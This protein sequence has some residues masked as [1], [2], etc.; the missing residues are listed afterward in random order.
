MHVAR[1]L[2][3]L[4][5]PHDPERSSRRTHADGIWASRFAD[6][7]TYGLYWGVHVAALGVFFTGVTTTALV[8]F[9]ITFWGRLFG[10][11]GGYHRYFAHK[12][13]KT[14]RPFQFLLAL[15]GTAA[16]Q[17]GPLWWASLHRIHHRES[18]GPGDVHS[19]K[20]GFYYSHQGWIFDKRWQATRLDLIP[21]FAK[22][23]EIQWLNRWHFVPPVALAVACFAIGGLPGLFWGFFLSTTLLWHATYTINSLSHLFG[24]RRFDTGDTSRNNWAARAAHLRRGLAQQPP[25]L[26][27]ERAPGLPLVGDR[28]HLLRA[29]RPQAV[30]VIWDVRE[31][32]AALKSSRATRSRA[33][34]QGGLRPHRRATP[35]RRFG[36]RRVRDRHFRACAQLRDLAGEKRVVLALGPELL[37]RLGDVVERRH[38]VGLTRDESHDPVAV[39]RLHGIADLAGRRPR[40]PARRCRR[41]DRAAPRRRSDRRA[42]ADRAVAEQRGE[43]ASDSPARAR[44]AISPA[45][46]FASDWEIAPIGTR[47]TS[48]CSGPGRTKVLPES[49]SSASSS[50]RCGSRIPAVVSVSMTPTRSRDARSARCGRGRARCRVAAAA[51]RRSVVE[52]A[53]LLGGIEIR[54]PLLARDRADEARQRIARDGLAVHHGD[55]VGGNARGRARTARRAAAHECRSGDRDRP[56]ARRRAASAARSPSPPARRSSR[57]EPRLGVGVGAEARMSTT[58]PVSRARSAAKPIR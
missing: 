10:I 7:L 33:A 4:P 13:F 34:A 19:P 36:P 29:A 44:R 24:T 22:Y 28:R 39:R 15:L 31:P 43:P 49:R 21:D 53:A 2:A 56:R 5:E 58:W 46:R 57:R 41:R 52:D 27:G 8:L 6:W 48:T 1:A 23:P 55:G 47:A 30:G 26:H 50:S 32:P 45:L 20:R 42:A 9:A 17:K 12:T 38:R 54:A 25:P 14:S 37:H 3:Q 40:S 51:P 16:T 11:T 35:A 18:D